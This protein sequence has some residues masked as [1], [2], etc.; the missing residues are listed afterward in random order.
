ML[1]INGASQLV[2]I[3]FGLEINPPVAG[4][5]IIKERAGLQIEQH[6]VDIDDKPRGTNLFQL[7]D[8]VV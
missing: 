1:T 5:E 7:P 3:K 4:S 8:I 2:L 6:L